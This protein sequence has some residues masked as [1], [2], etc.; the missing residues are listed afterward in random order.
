[1]LESALEQFIGNVFFFLTAEAKDPS[2]LLVKKHNE[3]LET[4]GDFSFP[5]SVKSWYR[6]GMCDQLK[7]QNDTSILRVIAKTPPDIV[8]DSETWKLHVRK[9]NEEN[10]RVYLFLERPHAIRVGLLESLR[11]KEI[12][13]EI[14]REWLLSSEVICPEDSHDLTTLR[15]NYLCN[16]IRN[17]CALSGVKHRIVVTTKSTFKQDG[18]QTV[19]CGTVLNS[20]SGAKETNITAEEFIRIRQDEM[21]LIAQ[22]KYGVRVSTDDKWK[23]FVAHLGQSAAAFELLQSKPSG[24]IKINFECASVGSSKG[25]SFILYNCARLETILKSYN[26]K[27]G[28]GTYPPLPDIDDVDLSLLTH[29]D[30]WNLIF[31]YIMGLPKVLNSCVEETAKGLEFRP[32]FICSFLSSMVRVISQYYR[33]VRIL[34][35]PRAHLLPVIFARIHMLNI[36]NETLKICLHILNIKSVSQM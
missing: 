6:Y 13:L 32:H 20:K 18:Y 21:T 34:V 30:E 27:V 5:S 3:N 2:S 10:G 33:R 35:E 28:E 9:A 25:A 19:L 11:N 12:I 4:H 17:L 36:L 1:M 8:E 7:I 23:E 26:D 22:H 31:N 15:A 16:V 14:L 29:E 24:A